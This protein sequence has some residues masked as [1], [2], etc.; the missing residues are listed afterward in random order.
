MVTGYIEYI[1]DISTVPT[2]RAKQRDNFAH[3]ILVCIDVV[4]EGH[5]VVAIHV[6]AAVPAGFAAAIYLAK[7]VGDD[8]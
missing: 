7:T 8:L 5:G 3:M 1:V 2:I 4:R 6:V